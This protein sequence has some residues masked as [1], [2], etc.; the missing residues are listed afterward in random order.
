[1][2]VTIWLLVYEQAY[3]CQYMIVGIW[4]G[5]WLLV[6][7]YKYMTPGIW[8]SRIWSSIWLSLYDCWYMIRHMTTSIWLQVYDFTYMITAHMV[9]IYDSACIWLHTYD[10]C[11]A[12]VNPVGTLTYDHISDH[13]CAHICVYTRHIYGDRIWSYACVGIWTH[14]WVPNI[15]IYGLPMRCWLAVCCRL[16]LFRRFRVLRLWLAAGE[17]I[18]AE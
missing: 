14:I 4:S 18:M 10:S 11:L 17:R 3:D 8:S 6:Y 15:I 7:D 5:I 1:M 12:Y 2:T 16:R 13:M 9:H